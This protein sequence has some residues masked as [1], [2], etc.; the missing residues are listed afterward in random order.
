M[1]SIF[2]SLL[3]SLLFVGCVNLKPAKVPLDRYALGPS[4]LA[5]VPEES[6]RGN[7]LYIDRPNIPAYME[8]DR[9]YLRGGNGQVS[10]IHG[11][12]WAEP[13]DE[14]LARALGEYVEINS[15]HLVRAYYPWKTKET[16]LCTVKLNV[17]KL[18]A[19]DDGSLLADIGWRLSCP[20]DE[21]QLGRY[22]ATLSWDPEDLTTYVATV[23]EAIEGLAA[24][25]IAAQ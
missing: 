2:I 22:Q 14:G 1:K 15:E 20:N 4:E 7:T 9:M 13:L 6:E 19:N 11:T 3:L 23:N 16:E 12:R 5:Q 25:I 8:A 21:A 18:I 10:A 17:Y 24:Q